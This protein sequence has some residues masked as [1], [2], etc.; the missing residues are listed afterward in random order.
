MSTDAQ[1]QKPLTH[2]TLQRR[3]GLWG[4]VFTGLGSMMGAGVFVSVAFAADL[5]GPQVL[6]AILLAAL[7]ALC[8]GLSSA[9]L[10]ANFPVAGG[11]YEYGY[12]LVGPQAGFLAGWLFVCAKSASAASAALAFAGYLLTMIDTGNRV[13]LVMIALLLIGGLTYLLQ[14]G[15]ERTRL[16]NFVIVGITVASLGIF[17]LVGLPRAL[18]RGLPVAESFVPGFFPGDYAPKDQKTLENGDSSTDSATGTPGGEGELIPSARR[19]R[20]L[21]QR[22]AARRLD[23]QTRLIQETAIPSAGGDA[24]IPD[25]DERSSME[26][27]PPPA[28]PAESDKPLGPAPHPIATSLPGGSTAEGL[29]KQEEGNAFLLATALM[30]V[31]FT[32]YGRIATMGEEVR[33]PKRNI[34]LAIGIALAVSGAL[35]LAVAAVYLVWLEPARAALAGSG[36]AYQTARNSAQTAPLALI[37]SALPLPG[38]GLLITLGAF[39]ALLGVLLNLILGLSR[40][41]LAM[42]RRGDM[43][44][45]LAKLEGEEKTPRLAI[46]VSGGVVAAL[47]LVGDIKLAWTFSAFTVLL[48]YGLTNV[49]AL[50]LTDEQRMFPKWLAGLGLMTCLLVA[51]TV[52]P[53]VWGIGLGILAAGLAWQAFVNP[54]PD[55]RAKRK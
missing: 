25:V 53:L 20:E 46:L 12:R 5:A 11:T 47:A 55:P 15:L 49:A 21:E 27:P 52:P 43:P 38:L 22:E 34:P 19:L 41:W 6:W 32:G 37:A 26:P 14:G 17:C 39:T 42:G 1:I 3:L 40:V 29:E 18:D 45:A 54:P 7:I 36:I 35:Y 9:Q 24:L 31:A 2:E 13:L 4:A 33:D 48:Y 23:E 10:A 51:C 50:R 8:N 16:F 28:E 30:F 44:G